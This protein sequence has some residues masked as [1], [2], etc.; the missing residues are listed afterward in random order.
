MSSARQHCSGQAPPGPPPRASLHSALPL[1]AK[2]ARPKGAQ[3]RLLPAKGPPDAAGCAAAPAVGAAAAGAAVRRAAA[4]RRWRHAAGTPCGHLRRLPRTGGHSR[5]EQRASHTGGCTS[6]AAGSLAAQFGTATAVS[7]CCTTLCLQYHPTWLGDSLTRCPRL[8]PMHVSSSACSQP[9]GFGL[10]Q[11]RPPPPT[12][13]LPA[14]GP[15]CC[16]HR[17]HTGHPA[18]L[19][20]PAGGK[21]RTCRCGE[22]ALH[23]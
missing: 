2:V 12:P 20:L 13:P 5:R 18:A 23:R 21:F 7:A 3:C 1:Q 8:S 22:W 17:T 11:G 10:Q 6:A 15:P 14:G 9:A 4:G 16:T 19:D